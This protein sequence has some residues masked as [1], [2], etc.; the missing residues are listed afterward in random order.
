MQ[1]LIGPRPKPP[2]KAVLRAEM[3]C[4]P[5]PFLVNCENFKCFC[6]ASVL[7]DG[8]DNIDQGCLAQK[9]RLLR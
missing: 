9:W 4:T 5:S 2:K 6:F 3:H 8:K 1:A 7:K